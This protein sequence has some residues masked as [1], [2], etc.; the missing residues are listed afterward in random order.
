M[1]YLMMAYISVSQPALLLV[2]SSQVEMVPCEG[3]RYYRSQMAVRNSN[4]YFC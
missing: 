1:F 2:N 4:S 3:R